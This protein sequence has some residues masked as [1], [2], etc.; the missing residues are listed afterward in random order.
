MPSGEKRADFTR[1]VGV[2][3][4][5][6]VAINPSKE[7]IKDLF[8]MDTLPEKEPE[9]VGTKDTEVPDHVEDGQVVKVTKTVK[10]C[11]VDVYIKDTK[12]DSIGKKAFFLWDRPFVKKDLSKQ[13]FINNL[14]KTSWVDDPA[15]LPKKFTHL[16]DKQGVVI[17][18]LNFHHSTVGESE[19]VEFLDSWLAIDKK[20]VYDMSV[21]TTNLF[22][23]N[24]REL[25]VLVESELASLIMGVYTVR[26]TDTEQGVQFW[27]DMWK[28]FLPAFTSKFF[29]QTE[30]TPEKLQEIAAK[31]LAV[32]AKISG[33]QQITNDDWL[34]NWEKYALEICDEEY[35]CKDSFSLKM[36]HDFDP[37]AHYSTNAAT[38]QA[39]SSEY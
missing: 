37:A 26:T 31:D 36:A 8:E 3:T 33:K 32:K 29:Q 10:F 16:L 22:N 23:G 15:N 5:K 4:G 20:K 39:D 24:F 27:Q 12:T 17:E 19:L 21:N 6:V 2:F 13:Q 14:G 35:G 9:Y 28:K 30:F 34:K 11:R 38:I 18:E 7:Q 1:K 25:Q